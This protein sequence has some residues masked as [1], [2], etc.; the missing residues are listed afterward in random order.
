MSGNLRRQLAPRLPGTF[1]ESTCP[2]IFQLSP[3]RGFQTF[4]TAL[5]YLKK[6]EA[7]R[8][9]LYCEADE[10]WHTA[11][12]SVYDFDL[13]ADWIETLRTHWNPLASHMRTLAPLLKA[14]GKLAANIPLEGLG[15]VAEKAPD[16]RA[17]PRLLRNELGESYRPS[18]IDIEFRSTL[19]EII[20]VLDTPRPP[21]QKTGGLK[22]WPNDDGRVLWLCP[23]HY[24]ALQSR[25]GP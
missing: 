9:S 8:L 7:W 2:N 19:H 4:D 20:T 21:A 6:G 23:R 16:I 15:L 12:H 17:D 18:R 10:E 13:H 5:E 24:R 22:K 11:Q 25:V 14:G 3:R 1:S